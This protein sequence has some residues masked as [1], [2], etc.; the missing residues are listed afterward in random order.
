VLK[1]S[2]CFAKFSPSTVCRGLVL[3]TFHCSN[4]ADYQY[5]VLGN[6]EIHEIH[7]KL[8]SSRENEVKSPRL[9]FNV[10]RIILYSELP[11]VT[12]HNL[13]GY[14]LIDTLISSLTGKCEPGTLMPCTHP[15]G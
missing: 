5:E 4:P 6:Y 14:M 9:R 1:K 11:L 8:A 13:L 7:L 2:C 3:V 15:G 12:L 10:F